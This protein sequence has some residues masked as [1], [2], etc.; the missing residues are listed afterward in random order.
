MAYVVSSGMAASE[1]RDRVARDY[2]RRHFMV[3]E[4]FS[5]QRQFYV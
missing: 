1:V 2:L 4:R 3:A 5:S